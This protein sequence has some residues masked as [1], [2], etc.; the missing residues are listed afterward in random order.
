MNDMKRRYARQ[1][2]YRKQAERDHA[3][4]FMFTM[5]LTFLAGCLC[6]ASIAMGWLA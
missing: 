2:Y 6:G 1:P 4:A 3:W 5:A